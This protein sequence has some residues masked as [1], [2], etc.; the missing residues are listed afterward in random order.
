MLDRSFLT[1]AALAV[2][3]GGA[4]VQLGQGRTSFA[5]GYAN[6]SARI[7][8]AERRAMMQAAQRE[9]DVADRIDGG[10]PVPQAEDPLG[11]GQMSPAAREQ[12]RGTL[13]TALAGGDGGAVATI[14]RLGI[15]EAPAF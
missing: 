9:M 3:L 8:A 7:A 6:V 13:R 1:V 5:D 12:A 11:Y 10:E 2:G 15:P 4:G 14:G